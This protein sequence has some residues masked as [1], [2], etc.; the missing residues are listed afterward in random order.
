M[1]YFYFDTLSIIHVP[2][3]LYAKL[4][5]IKVVVFDVDLNLRLKRI[6]RL[7]ERNAFYTRDITHH[8]LSGLSN[9][10][11][12]KYAEQIVDCSKNNKLINFLCENFQT[13]EIKLVFKKNLAVSLLKITTIDNYFNKNQRHSNDLVT[14]FPLKTIESLYLIDIKRLSSLKSSI[15]VVAPV[16]TLVFFRMLKNTFINFNLIIFYITHVFTQRKTTDKDVLLSYTSGLSLS[17]PFFTKFKGKRKFDFILGDDDFLKEESVFVFEYR[18]DVFVNDKVKDGYNILVKP[19]VKGRKDIVKFLCGKGSLN[20]GHELKTVLPIFFS[21]FQSGYISQTLRTLLYEKMSWNVFLSQYKFNQYVYTNKESSSQISTNIVLRNHKVK[22]IAYSQFIGGTYQIDN[23]STGFDN[24]NV[25]WSFL[26][27]DEFIVNNEGMKQSLLKHPNK[28]RH[29]SVAGNIFSQMIKESIPSRT[30][31]KENTKKNIVFFDTSYVDISNLYSSYEEAVEYLEHII[32][33]SYELPDNTYY[34][35]PSKDDGYFVDVKLAWA[36]PSKGKK[37]IE[38]R[39][40]LKKL[41]NV[42]FENTDKDTVD[43]IAHCDLVITNCFS[44]LVADAASS[45]IDAFWHDASSTTRGFPLDEIPEM[46]THGYDELAERI[47]KSNDS[48][49]KNLWRDDRFKK[50]VDPYNDGKSLDRVRE[51]IVNS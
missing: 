22:T 44:S 48:I 31:D 11:A 29:I 5:K 50:M 21:I 26:N 24:K 4:F 41:N 7:L 49:V 47:L 16:K 18:D 46:V 36:S 2:I 19:G 27:C 37:I 8:G 35:K 1:R 9:T 13:D 6:P 10:K 3:I 51:I 38:L 28:I 23:K 33:I 12:I 30:N 34:F 45:G 42:V 20:K 43:L 17:A 40:K 32:K 15:K 25:L 39:G 14:F